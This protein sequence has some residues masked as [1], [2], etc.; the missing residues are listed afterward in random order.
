MVF[1]AT[2]NNISVIS[3]RC[4]YQNMILILMLDII[5]V[6]VACFFHFVKFSHLAAFCIVCCC[7]IKLQKAWQINVILQ[8]SYIIRRVWRYQR[9]NQNSYI[10]E[11]TTQWPKEKVQKD[12]QRSTKHT[13]KTDDRVTRTPIQTRGAISAIMIKA[14]VCCAFIL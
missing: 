6:Y 11:Q 8:I 4:W 14:F 1:N 2:F 7:N 13:H 5:I 10:E 9:G 12:K 3:W